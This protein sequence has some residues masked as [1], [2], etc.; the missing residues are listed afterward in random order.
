MLVL[1]EN[2]Y[3]NN[4]WRTEF[5]PVGFRTM[6]RDYVPAC[7]F[8]DFNFKRHNIGGGS[9]CI[10]F[11]FSVMK[12]ISKVNLRSQFHKKVQESTTKLI[13]KTML[14]LLWIYIFRCFEFIGN[15]MSLLHSI[16]RIFY[17]YISCYKNDQCIKKTLQFH[18]SDLKTILW[19]ICL[20]FIQPSICMPTVLPYSCS[21]CNLQHMERNPGSHKPLVHYMVSVQNT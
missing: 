11:R 6:I 5:C 13:L 2:F 10:I 15:D 4:R 7:R 19:Y 3:W 21:S 16:I 17:S 1:S 18:Q 12:H 14:I 9:F 8:V 20:C